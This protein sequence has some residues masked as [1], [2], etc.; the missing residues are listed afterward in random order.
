MGEVKRGMY[1]ATCCKKARS[2]PYKE[3]PPPFTHGYKWSYKDPKLGY[4]H[5]NLGFKSLSYC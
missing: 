1:H 4:K 5:P 3:A 2:R